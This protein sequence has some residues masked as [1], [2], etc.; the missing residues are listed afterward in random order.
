MSISQR[1]A[2]PGMFQVAIRDLEKRLR[3]L[4]RLFTTILLSCGKSYLK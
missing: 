4:A 2:D 1:L 3:I